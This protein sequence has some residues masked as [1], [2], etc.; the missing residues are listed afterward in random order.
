MYN[1][2]DKSMIRSVYAGLCATDHIRPLFIE[3]DSHVTIEMDS[4]A[5]RKLAEVICKC[6]AFDASAACESFFTYELD[7]SHIG[8]RTALGITTGFF[9]DDWAL[10]VPHRLMKHLIK[11]AVEEIEDAG[12]LDKKEIFHLVQ[13]SPRWRDLKDEYEREMERSD[14]AA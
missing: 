7:H 1:A 5:E 14:R 9:N 10:D 12:I 3:S 6:D 8:N 11:V 4:E 13:S 2:N